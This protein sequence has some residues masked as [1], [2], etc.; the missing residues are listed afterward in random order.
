MM[1]RLPFCQLPG[2]SSA[3]AQRRSPALIGLL[4]LLSPLAL[5]GGC[6]WGSPPAEPQAES[7]GAGESAVAEESAAAEE[8]AEITPK[9]YE[10]SAEAL[11][12][13]RL[14]RGQATEGWVRLFD[15]HTLYGWE[16]AGEANWQ[17]KDETITVDSGEQCLL[18]T[19]I[20]WRDY[21][22]T[23]EFNADPETNSGV[24]L[25]TP[26]QPTDPAL[27]CYEVNIAPDDHPFPTGSVV[28][29]Q[30]VD[31]EKVPAAEDDAWRRM[32]MR[33][34]GDRLQVLLDGQ[35]VCDYRDEIGLGAG[36]IGLQKNSGRIAF[37]DIRLR[38]LN[39]E[40]L[41]D[42]ELSQWKKYPEMP[43]EFTTTDDGS[44]HVRGG[45]SQ[46][47]SEQ[48]YGD[49][50]LLAEYKLAEP[51]M[52]SG[53]F[54]RCIPGSEMMG[55]EC[56]IS[57]EM[58]DGQPLRPADCGTGGIFRRQ[59]ARIIAGRPGEWNSVLLTVRGPRM[60]A[61]VEGLQVSDW[62]D[63]REKHENPRKGRRLE[64]GTLMIQ[65]HDPGT[66]VLFRKI[67]IVS[68]D[69]SGEPAP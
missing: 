60:A 24:F 46:L 33:L 26:L 10:A 66:D 53:I 37:R 47:E 13:S 15:G 5:S 11:L 18:C 57:N 17:V 19:S 30:K 48:S 68:W 9:T 54:F 38:P 2:R 64:P 40:S 7:A 61:W 4:W 31:S 1:N 58:A 8:A 36:R 65:G 22:L 52:N 42:D 39:L 43:G 63:T 41:L 44:L 34:E 23:L 49:F 3:A 69:E 6:Y 59:D 45:R 56:Q 51:E 29:R 27:E 21:E 28:E 67:A 20:P 16:I 25:R 32:T 14:P 12:A 50:T 55:Y 35:L 62:R